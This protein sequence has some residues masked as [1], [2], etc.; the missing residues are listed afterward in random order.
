MHIL[1]FPSKIWAKKCT[2]YMAKYGNWFLM[3]CEILDCQFILGR[4]F[5]CE[6]SLLAKSNVIYPWK[7]RGFPDIALPSISSHRPV[8]ESF[9]SSC[10]PSFFSSFFQ[11]PRQPRWRNSPAISFC[12]SIV[13]LCHWRDFIPCYCPCTNFVFN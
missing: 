13:S 8:D 2:L 6:K 11:L 10:S 7:N 5:P 3:C 9:L 12:F 4:V 1:I